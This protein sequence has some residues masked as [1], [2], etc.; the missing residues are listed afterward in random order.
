MFKKYIYSIYL[1]IYLKSMI[2]LTTPDLSNFSMLKVSIAHWSWPDRE[3][4]LHNKMGSEWA[5][6]ETKGDIWAEEGDRHWILAVEE[7]GRKWPKFL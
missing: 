5:G 7:S 6:K 2:C 1:F 4:H 3:R